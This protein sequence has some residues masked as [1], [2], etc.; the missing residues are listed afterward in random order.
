MAS[1]QNDNPSTPPSVPSPQEPP[2]PEGF[3]DELRR[4][5]GTPRKSNPNPAHPVTRVT[6]PDSF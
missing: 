3:I 5:G 1:T 2:A 4:P 6:L